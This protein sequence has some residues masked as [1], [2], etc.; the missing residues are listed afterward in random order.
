M[1]KF[2]LQIDLTGMCLVDLTATPPGSGQYFGKAYLL[3][4]RHKPRLTIPVH[5][6][7]AVDSGHLTRGGRPVVMPGGPILAEID[8]SQCEVRV[9][10]GG[11]SGVTLPH[12]DHEAPARLQ[13]PKPDWRFLDY[14]LDLEHQAGTNQLLPNPES[15]CAATIVLDRGRMTS[16]MPA[17]P[18]MARA[19]WNMTGGAQA[20]TQPVAACLRWTIDVP[21]D[22]ALIQVTSG[23]RQ[24]ASIP[25]GPVT[26]ADT[27]VPAAMYS[28]CELSGGE[29][30]KLKDVLEYGSLLAGGTAPAVPTQVVASVTPDGSGC[31]PVRLV[32]G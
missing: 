6:M 26:A 18:I 3:G 8:L 21:T 30:G 11:A 17:N 24:I 7:R 32:R 12:W 15:R 5:F 10:G 16:V 23:G 28:L 25:V 19:R 31:P 13:D 9:D 14:A 1:G 27:A 29:L 20:R 2:E 22:T 4:G